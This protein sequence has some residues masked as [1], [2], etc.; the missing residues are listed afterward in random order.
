MSSVASYLITGGLGF[1][2]F[3]AALR[4]AREGHAVTLFDN[5]SRATARRNL[6]ALEKLAPRGVRLVRGD[7]RHPRELEEL[8]RR[9]GGFDRVLHLAGQVALTES[10]KDPRT[11][12]E[13]N[14]MGTFNL[15]EAVRRHSPRSRVLFASTNKVYGDLAW[16]L[17]KAGPERW[18]LRRPA[19]GVPETAPLE[20]DS[21]YAR[22]KAAGEQFVLHAAAQGLCAGVL[23]Q[24]CVYGPWQYGEEE[25][26]WVAWFLRAAAAGKDITIYGDGRQARDLLYID[27]LLDLYDAAFARAARLRGGVFNAGGGP[28]RASSPREVLGWVGGRLKRAPRLHRGPW[29]RGDQKAYVSDLSRAG[30]ELGWRPRVAVEDGLNRLFDWTLQ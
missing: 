11:D 12:F 23:R 14:A 27:D 7:V 29:R 20:P 17:V 1:I 19:G 6:P 18:E 13:V 30:R 24:S 21:P 22:S 25:Q 2:G 8:I 16:G 15:L 5:L 4:W 3:N 28:E 9:R 10:W 26:G